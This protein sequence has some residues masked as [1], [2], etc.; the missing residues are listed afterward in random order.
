[1]ITTYDD[2]LKPGTIADLDLMTPEAREMILS[3]ETI[4]ASGFQELLG[5]NGRT[6]VW[7]AGSWFE[8]EIG[9]FHINNLGDGAMIPVWPAGQE[10][11]GFTSGEGPRD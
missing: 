3:T 11:L 8:E 9:K 2:R 4:R 7:A 6:L 1:M 5:H 10:H